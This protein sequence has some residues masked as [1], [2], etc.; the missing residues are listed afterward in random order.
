M[1][2]A[3]QLDGGWMIGMVGVEALNR[4]IQIEEYSASRIVAYHALN[5]EK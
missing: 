1:I 5:P 4:H 2:N 3:R